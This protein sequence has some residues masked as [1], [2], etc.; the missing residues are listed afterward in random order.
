[1]RMKFFKASWRYLI[2]FVVLTIIGIL[3]LTIYQEENNSGWIKPLS[4]IILLFAL[5]ILNLGLRAALIKQFPKSKQFTSER[6]NYRFVQLL[7]API[8]FMLGMLFSGTIVYE[9]EFAEGILT[10]SSVLMAL[11]GVLLTIARFPRTKSELQNINN[12]I[13]RSTLLLSLFAGFACMFLVLFWFA[14]VESSFLEWAGLTFFI[15]FGY[16]ILFLFF[17]KYYIKQ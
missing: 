15:Q 6:F 13:I 8:G 12:S 4:V 10:A 14:K 9:K 11:S 5:F 16:V 1:M 7:V 17:P 3:L 2:V